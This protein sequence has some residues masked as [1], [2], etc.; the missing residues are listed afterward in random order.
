VQTALVFIIYVIFFN[1]LVTRITFIKNA[2]LRAGWLTGLFSLKIIAGLVYAWFYL[3]PAYYATSDTW[4]YFELSKAETD[5]LLK[6]PLAF[7]KDIFT[8][9]YQQTGNLFLQ[10][11]S[12]WNDLKSNIIIKLLALCNVFTFKNY[13]A[14]IVFFNFIFFFGPVALYRLIKQLFPINKLLL[15]TAVFLIPSFL[16]WC[17]GI[18]KDGL[19]FACIALVVFY[20][21][22]QIL[23]RKIN[24]SSFLVLI[25]CLVI[26]FALR[27]FMALLLLPALLVWFLSNLF[28]SKSRRI[29]IGIYGAGVILF[30]VSTYISLQT[31]LPGYIIQKQNEFK[32]LSGNSA[33]STP[34]LEDNLFSFIRFLPTAIDIAFFRPHITEI[35]NKSYIPAV[36]EIIL[37]WSVTIYS[38]FIKR[39]KNQTAQQTA[40]IIFCICFSISFLLIAG[41]TIT[42]S[43][44]IVR[45]RAVVLPFVFIPALVRINLIKKASLS[46]SEKV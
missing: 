7:L 31:D 43:G 4:R 36:V 12:Y 30:F 13:F 37:L 23:N 46:T 28:P 25:I 38:F 14:D 15:I 24:L 34:L 40:F 45:Y 42:F 26:L 44:A 19:I 5:W 2:G 33:I 20:F 29:T 1:W 17:S 22:K 21:Y 32:Q 18:H 27:N 8:N 16:F 11:N 10:S 41:Y 6:D 9:G 3:Q 39:K 35:R